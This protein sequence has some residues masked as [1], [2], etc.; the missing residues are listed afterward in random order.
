MKIGCSIL[1]IRWVNGVRRSCKVNSI[2]ITRP[3]V[4][5]V[6]VQLPDFCEQS[7]EE[8]DKNVDQV[9]IADEVVEF[10]P[11]G[12]RDFFPFLSNL[13]IR[14]CGL[15]EISKD[16]LIGLEN[17]EFLD[18]SSNLLTSLPDDLFV[19][20]QVLQWI[21][22]H[23]NKLRRFSSKLLEPTQQNLIFADFRKNLKIDEFF[24]AQSELNTLEN[25][26]AVIEVNCVFRFKKFEE[27]YAS[28]KY[29]DFTIKTLAKEFKVHKCIL[30]AQSSVFESMFTN[31]A[32]KGS[33]ILTRI[34]NFNETAFEKFLRFFYTEVIEMEN[35]AI[36]LFELAS[37]FNVL[38][39][40]I[41]CE[42]AIL[43]QIDEKSAL[44]VF[45]LAHTHIS[46][47]LKRAAFDK[48]KG[49]FPEITDRLID[50][51]AIVNSVVNTI[52]RLDIPTA[53]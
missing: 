40:K 35:H 6:S 41:I 43:S 45:N 7:D 52:N 37:E 12:L 21:D 27:L 18:L 42:N 17:L 16:D 31:E 44:E 29:S 20:T 39:L 32:K 53:F 48:I 13:V 9:W 50:E 4:E 46:M 26:M 23:E 25:L 30:A 51:P 33:L 14:Q 2:S 8:T 15:K 3:N 49:Q 19:H 38:A 1:D 5:I 24:D 10:L 47:K 36:E 28:G 22:F 34:K 11:R